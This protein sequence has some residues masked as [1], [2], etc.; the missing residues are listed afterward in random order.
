MGKLFFREKYL[1]QIREFYAENDNYDETG[2][3]LTEEREYRPLE[4]ISDGYPKYLLTMDKLLQCRHLD[5]GIFVFWHHFLQKK[6]VNPGREVE[7]LF[8]WLKGKPLPLADEAFIDF[9]KQSVSSTW[10]SSGT[11]TSL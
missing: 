3:N 8:V 1:S 4:S 6:I 9:V 7:Y 10:A 11:S 2:K 5:V